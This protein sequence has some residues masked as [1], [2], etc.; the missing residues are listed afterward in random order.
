[1]DIDRNLIWEAYL[2]EQ[3][4]PARTEVL[5]NLKAAQPPQS[6]EEEELWQQIMATGDP[7]GSLLAKQRE[8]QAAA[9]PAGQSNDE[10]IAQAEADREQDRAAHTAEMDK[11]MTDFSAQMK[12]A[13]DAAIAQSSLAA[14]ELKAAEART[15]AGMAGAAQQPAAQPNAQGIIERPETEVN[16]EY[17]KYMIDTVVR[18]QSVPKFHGKERTKFTEKE[19]EIAQMVLDATA[20]TA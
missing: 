9:Q 12:A 11:M 18:N 19:R 13:Q 17:V 10:L 1:M 4:D 3:P 15:D 6:Q 7:D 20:A 5:G 16:P 8:L 2:I 14:D